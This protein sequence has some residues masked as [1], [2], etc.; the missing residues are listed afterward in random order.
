MAGKPVHD[1]LVFYPGDIV[2]CEGEEGNWAYLIQSGKIEIFNVRPDGSECSLAV[3]G[4]GRLF[5]EMAL[6][7]AAPRMASAR[8]VE[9]TTLVLVNN[10]VLTQSLEKASPLVRELLKNLSNN[11][12]ALTRK[13]LAD[14]SESK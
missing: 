2:F 13:H 7:D 6:I 4:P 10:K 5:G 8:A 1:R 11:L 9:V 14:T 3:I 12:R